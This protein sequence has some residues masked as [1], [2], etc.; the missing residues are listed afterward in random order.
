R[1]NVAPLTRRRFFLRRDRIACAVALLLEVGDDIL[2]ERD[3]ALALGLRRRAPLLAARAL[4]RDLEL[5]SGHRSGV[6]VCALLR[7]VL[8]CEDV[9]VILRANRHAGSFG[10]A[11]GTPL[12]HRVPDLPQV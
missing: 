9:P 2:Q 10:S 12:G 3:H 6:V 1:A 8:M 7:G 4:V 5:E 11:S